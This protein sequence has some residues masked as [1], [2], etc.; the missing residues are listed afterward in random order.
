MS[1]MLA[2]I[3]WLIIVMLGLLGLLLITPVLLRVHLTNSPKFAYRVEMLAVGGLAPRVTLAQGPRQDTVARQKIKQAKPKRRRSSR[4]KRVYG[5][6]IRALPE[7][8]R[9]M[10]RH[11]HLAELHIDADYGFGDPADTGELSGLLMPLQY[12]HPLPASVSLNLR[13]VFTQSCLKGSLTTAV[14]VTVAAF[15]VPILRF[16]WRAFGPGK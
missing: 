7:L 13:P 8:M 12:A 6:V 11:I 4:P 16:A 14:R 2:I 5:A 10:L 1:V 9:V 15:L 3:L